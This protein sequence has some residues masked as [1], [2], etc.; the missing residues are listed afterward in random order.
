MI[1]YYHPLYRPPAEADS[2]ILQATYGC[3][4]NGCTF[5]SMYKSKKYEARTLQELYGEIDLL[6]KDYPGTTKVFLADGDALSLPTDHLLS[7]LS[8]LQAHF[9]KLRRVSVYATAQNILNKSLQELRSLREHKLML[10]YFGIETGDEELLTKIHKGVNAEEMI[11]ALNKVNEAGIKSS[12]TLIL[13]L[14]GKAFTHQ[15]ISHTAELINKS[16]IT[17]LSTLQ[18]GLDEQI[19]KL[20][21]HQF[22]SFETLDDYAILDEQRRLLKQLNPKSPVIFRSNHASNALHLAGNLPKDQHRLL[23]EIDQALQKGEASL[24]PRALR[25]F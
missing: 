5:C 3:S 2:L 25:G 10:L 7:L 21:L 9:P 1:N 17:Y 4:H 13:G 15:H 23:T 18:L 16:K 8:Y 6:C 22:E 14:G 11:T 24:V 19:K 12:A 20:F